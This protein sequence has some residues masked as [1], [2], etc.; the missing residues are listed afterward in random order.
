MA[1]LQQVQKGEVLSAEKWNARIQKM[2]SLENTIKSLEGKIQ[3]LEK[4]SQEPFNAVCT[5]QQQ[6]NNRFLDAHENKVHDYSV[7]TRPAQNNKTQRWIIK[8]IKLKLP[9][10]V[11]SVTQVTGA[12]GAIGGIIG[13]IGPVGPG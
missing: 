7:T 10:N 12:T 4:K 3:T 6:S 1:T 5:V 8:Q 13:A 9:W 11:G 2:D